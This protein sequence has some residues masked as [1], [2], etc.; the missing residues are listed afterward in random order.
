ML[1]EE[2]GGTFTRSW[3]C[4]GRRTGVGAGELL[5]IGWGR[6]G[7]PGISVS[8]AEDTPFGGRKSLCCKHLRVVRGETGGRR[9]PEGC[10]EVI[11]SMTYEDRGQREIA[12]F[13]RFEGRI[14]AI[15]GDPRKRLCKSLWVKRLQGVECERE[16]PFKAL[17][18]LREATSTHRTLV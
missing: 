6:P 7:L 14:G 2:V 8:Y 13:G 17:R 9:S 3:L 12:D 11:E 5:Q 1:L 16:R 10:F 18:P 4:S 15:P